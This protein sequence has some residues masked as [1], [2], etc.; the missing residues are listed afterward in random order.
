MHYITGVALAL[1]WYNA[2][3]LETAA[4]AWFRFSPWGSDEHP[5]KNIFP[6]KN[7][8]RISD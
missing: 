3:V 2:E 4:S 7:Q 1:H 6:L 5:K 8:S